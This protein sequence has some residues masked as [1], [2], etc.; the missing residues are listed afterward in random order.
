MNLLVIQKSIVVKDIM[1]VETDL[2]I[3]KTKEHVKMDLMMVE[4]AIAIPIKSVIQDMSLELMTTATWSVGI[5]P[6]A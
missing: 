5:I 1:M 4:M 2:A 6:I 3:Q